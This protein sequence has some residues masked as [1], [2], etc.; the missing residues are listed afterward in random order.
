MLDAPLPRPARSTPVATLVFTLLAA[1]AVFT[2]VYDLA[3]IVPLSLR[4][5]TLISAAACLLPL[6]ASLRRVRSFLVELKADLVAQTREPA[7]W[8]LLLLCLVAGGVALLTHWFNADDSFYLSRAVLS[9]ENF[10]SPIEATY[11]F[12][13]THGAGGRFPS[14]P[15]WEHLWAA[16]AA[17]IGCHP[18]DIYGNVGPFLAGAL[19]PWAWAFLLDRISSTQRAVLVGVATLLILMLVDG[20]THRGV[21][22][23]GLLR[24]WQGKVVL[25]TVVAPL[26]LAVTLDLLRGG[27]ARDWLRLLVLG[28][29]GVGLTTTSAFLLP[30]LVGVAGG[31][32]WL[33]E[34]P[35]TPA[36]RSLLAALAVFAYPALCV[37]PFYRDLVGPKAIFADD[38][39]DN[40]HDILLGVYGRDL[41]PTVVTVLLAL[42]SLMLLRRK[43]LL[44]WFA[45]WGAVMA[46]PLE[47][48]PSADF[49]V[50]HITSR[51][52]LWRLA[53][54]G[55]C[56]LVAA[57]GIGEL[58][59]VRVLRWLV[60]AALAGAA[61]GA[62]VLAVLLIAPSPY[63]TPDITFPEIAPRAPAKELATCRKLLDALPPGTLLAPRELSVVLPM[64]SSRLRLTNFREFD[65]APQLVLDGRPEVAADLTAAHDYVS[66]L[67][68]TPAGRHGLRRIAALG[69]DA[70]VL[71]PAMP[72]PQGA[73]DVLL[74]TGFHEITLPSRYR[75]FVRGAARLSGSPPR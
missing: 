46:V 16:V 54:A 65:A 74:A 20:T 75:A 28:V 26:A 6:L 39:A 25:I 56:L 10:G 51:D 29:A 63:S 38:V 58:T 43:R 40:L 23:F 41:A 22:K 18:L 12:A 47:W 8:W 64:L 11:P 37:L 61:V 62:V 15:A 36:W 70:V 48:K 7:A 19:V 45:L 21:A 69:L 9:W 30:I 68:N 52:A 32:Y 4:G 57:V 73:V 59:T 67:V 33:V 55:P 49:I 53:Y 31:V 44:A 3:L 35:P 13:F 1:F 71:S 42:V 72:Q 5:V 24:I 50:Q 27:R 2:F 60:P 34:R 66:G 17:L 14:L